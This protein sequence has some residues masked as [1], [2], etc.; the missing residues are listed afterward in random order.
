[1]KTQ[2]IDVVVKRKYS[3]TPTVVGLE[4]VSS[5]GQQLPAYEAGAHINVE[6][7]G[8]FVRQYSLC[9]TPLDCNTY[10]LGILLDPKSRGGSKSA[11]EQLIEGQVVRIS[12]P[13]NLFPLVPGEHSILLAGGIG[14][15]PILSMAYALANESSSF[16]M[17]YSA[18]S[19]D[20]AAFIDEL[21]GTVFADHLHLYLDDGVRLSAEAVLA[22]PNPGIYLYVCGPQGFISHV[23]ETAESLGWS[24]ANIRFELFSAPIME[25]KDANDA[26]E[27]ELLGSGKVV[28]VGPE[29]TAAQAMITAGIPV[30]ISCEQG[31]CGNCMMRVH[32]GTPDHRDFFLSDAERAANDQFTPCC[33]RALSA[34]LIVDFA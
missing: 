29:E 26:F 15:T 17:H 24:K 25:R 18:R 2:W 8:G 34:R 19:R 4:L 5:D 9:G 10:R 31:I 22:N 16:E 1:M 13:Q 30:P 32:S 20:H 11:H 33:S 6:L 3:L 23:T 21:G 7:P 27:I 28:T 14:I 12:E